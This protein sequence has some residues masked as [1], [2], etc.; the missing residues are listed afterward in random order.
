LQGAAEYMAERDKVLTTFQ[1]ADYCQVSPF[2]IRN[3]IESGVLRGYKTPGGHRRI[4]K[5]DLDEF[6]KKH[7]M[8]VPDE[9]DRPVRNKVLVVDDDKAVNDFV[10]KIVAQVDRE[11]E[12]AVATDGFEAGAK[13]ASFKPHVV[14]LD[15]R[16]PGLDGF[17]VCEKIKGDPAV[18][19]ATVIGI[20]GYHSTEYES[21]FIACG[22]AKLLKKPLDVETLKTAVGEALS[23]NSGTLNGDAASPNASRRS[24]WPE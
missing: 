18:A 13:V 9:P 11:A 1:A 7:G 5:R 2:T 10:S 23:R 17:Q 16:M 6:L 14:I 22:G 20:T 4:L 19:G 15:L 3:W 24:S 8:P 21:R 12:I